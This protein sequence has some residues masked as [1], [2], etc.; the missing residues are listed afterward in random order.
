MMEPVSPIETFRLGNAP[1][2]KTFDDDVLLV[3]R[4]KFGRCRTGKQ[5]AL[6]EPRNAVKRNRNVKTRLRND[7]NHAPKPR[8][9]PV[10][11]GIHCKE[12]A[13]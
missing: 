10:L 12:R 11:G 6:V 2:R 5:Q 7:A 13:H 1:S 9:Q 3:D 4:Q 8:D